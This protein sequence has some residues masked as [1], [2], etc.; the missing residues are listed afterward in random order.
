MTCWTAAADGHAGG[1]RFSGFAFGRRNGQLIL[2][3]KGNGTPRA[4]LVNQR[5][6]RTAAV[7]VAGVDADVHGSISGFNPADFPGRRVSEYLRQLWDRCELIKVAPQQSPDGLVAPAGKPGAPY[8]MPGP[9]V[10]NLKVLPC[11]PD[12]PVEPN[13]QRFDGKPR[14]YPAAGKTRVRQQGAPVEP[15]GQFGGL[16]KHL[17]VQGTVKGRRFFIGK[18]GAR[19]PARKQ[20][21]QIVVS[22]QKGEAWIVQTGSEPSAHAGRITRFVLKM[23]EV[24][25]E[26]YDLPGI[27]AVD[28]AVHSA[29]AL[30]RMQVSDDEDSIQILHGYLSAPS[31]CG[32]GCRSQRNLSEQTGIDNIF[33]GI[34]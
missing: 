11:A 13:R 34:P 32:S 20:V 3:L 2:P 21:G 16:S 23:I 12:F 30:R 1:C 19:D 7:G 15:V 29:K 33:S 18:P 9:S 6:A 17:H 4:A 25:A 26:Q 27:Y 5:L 10:G 28:K 14:R 24:I 31:V 8:P 22:E